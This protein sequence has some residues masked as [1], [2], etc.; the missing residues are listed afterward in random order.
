MMGACGA[1]DDV[2]VLLRQIFKQ[3]RFQM[4]DDNSPQGPFSGIVVCALPRHIILPG[5]NPGRQT[6]APAGN[7]RG[8]SG[9]N[10]WPEAFCFC[11][12]PRLASTGAHC[13]NSSARLRRKPIT[14]LRE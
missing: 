13:L 6:L 7:T 10:E 3:L 14:L 1:D 2:G 9:G 4:I 8:G 5:E 11:G 12:S